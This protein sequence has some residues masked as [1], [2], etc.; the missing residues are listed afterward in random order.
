MIYNIY[1]IKAQKVCGERMGEQE[2][3]P[4]LPFS[5]HHH[6]PPFL[7]YLRLN[8]WLPGFPDG[9]DSKEPAGNAGDLGSIP[10]LGRSLGEGNGHPL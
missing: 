2:G 6:Q 3:D 1:Q 5:H 8:A 9:S 4:H 10:G 7:P